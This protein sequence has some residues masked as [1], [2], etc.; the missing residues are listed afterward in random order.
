MNVHGKLCQRIVFLSRGLFC[1]RRL[2]IFER[3]AR[4]ISGPI[5]EC[6]ILMRLSFAKNYFD[7]IH[8]LS[9]LTRNFQKE[10]LKDIYHG[11]AQRKLL[12]YFPFVN[13]ST[14]L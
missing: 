11:I 3:C 10:I 8:L 4:V 1:L 9:G 14:N 2:E 12:S 13:G 7:E 5:S 6:H